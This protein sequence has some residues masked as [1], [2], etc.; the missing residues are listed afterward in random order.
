MRDDFAALGHVSRMSARRIGWRFSIGVAQRLR[1]PGN[2]EPGSRGLRNKFLITTAAATL[3][4]WHGG[5]RPGTIEAEEDTVEN[6]SEHGPRGDC[7]R[8]MND[9]PG[10]SAASVVACWC[11]RR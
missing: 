6:R 9:E 5:R 8:S 4:A 7:P 1:E 3:M 10:H 11:S 2:N